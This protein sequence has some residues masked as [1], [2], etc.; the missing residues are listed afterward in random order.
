MHL[1]AS[2]VFLSWVRLG[3]GQ[4]GPPSL[5]CPC[6]WWPAHYLSLAWFGDSAGPC[7]PLPVWVSHSGGPFRWLFGCLGAPGHIGAAGKLG[8]LSLEMWGRRGLRRFSCCVKSC[9]LLSQQERKPRWGEEAVFPGTAACQIGLPIVLFTFSANS[10]IF[11]SRRFWPGDKY[12]R[13]L[14]KSIARR[15]STGLWLDRYNFDFYSLWS[16]PSLISLFSKNPR[17]ICETGYTGQ[18]EAKKAVSLATAAIWK[19]GK[20]SLSHFSFHFLWFL[21]GGQMLCVKF[22]LRFCLW[23]LLSQSWG[24]QITVRVTDCFCLFQ[25]EM[26]TSTQSHLTVSFQRIPEYSFYLWLP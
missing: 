17:R 12:S 8:A 4:V 16:F 11:S 18:V 1:W 3:D 5:R 13:W 15:N 9:L 7:L 19:A 20:S 22:T 26:S 10:M 6:F 25:L 14:G 23:Y 2:S 21:K 24:R